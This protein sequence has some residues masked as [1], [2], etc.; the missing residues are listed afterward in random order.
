[1]RGDFGSVQLQDEALIGCFMGYDLHIT[2]VAPWHDAE[3]NPI[4]LDEWAA[5]VAADPE[6][7]MD[8]F[9]EAKVD[10]GILWCESEGLAVWTVYS[11]HGKN[12]NMAWFDYRSGRIAVKNPDDEI[13]RKMKA[14]AAHFGAKVLGDDGESY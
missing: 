8:G 9:A 4:T 1:M 2:R 13:I 11:G 6:M 3:S 10:G 12:G 5:Y 7:R 14:I